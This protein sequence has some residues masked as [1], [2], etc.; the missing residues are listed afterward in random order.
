MINIYKSFKKQKI[1]FQHLN[2]LLKLLGELQ[3]CILQVPNKKKSVFLK[4]FSAKG[5]GIVTMSSLST[6]VS[7]FGVASTGTAIATLSGAAKMS[8]TMAALGSVVGGGMAAGGVVLALTGF[9]AGYFLRNT[10]GNLWYGKERKALDLSADE[11]RIREI[12]SSL[13][14]VINEFLNKNN[15]YTSTR[16]LITFVSSGLV[17]L[18][19]LI[20]NSK[21]DIQENLRIGTRKEFKSIDKKIVS[22]SS[23][24]QK[25]FSVK[26]PNEYLSLKNAYRYF[27]SKKVKKVENIR[28]ASVCFTVFLYKILSNTNLSNQILDFNESL[29][30]EAF[31]RSA[32]RFENASVEE[33]R[34]YITILDPN[35]ITGWI[36]NA[37][38][39]YHELLWAKKENIDGDNL[40]AR[41]FE[42]TN[43][44]GSDIEFIIDGNVVKE[45]QFKAVS[46]PESIAEH[47]E[48]YPDIEVYATSEV[49]TKVKD[50]F[51]NVKD[52]GFSL[53]EINTQTNNFIFPENPDMFPDAG[54]GAAI[55]IFIAALKNR[56]GSKSFNKKVRESLKLG[57]VGASTAVALE[58]LLFG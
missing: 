49:A 53:E 26:K 29:I 42:E 50:I 21:D 43:H 9:G 13:S 19:N 4:I 17:P 24:I 8:A 3:L 47:F 15:K 56:K 36:S 44:A 28:S 55:G 11:I 46:N 16:D 5:S 51:E 31:Q 20:N 54:A 30:L 14:C 18:L 25:D 39:I 37:K 2:E 38:G 40:T 57:T 41:L 27:R 7:S 32:K 1:V 22:L 10:L 35:Q 34:E 52:S 6:A 33:I 45:V 12:S 58:Y 48:K 23:K